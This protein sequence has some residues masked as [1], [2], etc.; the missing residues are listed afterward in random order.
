M[1]SLFFYFSPGRESIELKKP[2][3]IADEIPTEAELTPPINAPRKPSS[4]TD[5]FT[6]LARTFPKPE[7]GTV[8]PQPAKFTRGV[9]KSKA[10]K[11]TPDVTKITIILAG[12]NFVKSIKTCPITQIR[13][14][15]QKALKYSKKSLPNNIL[16]TVI[17]VTAIFW[18]INFYYL[19]IK[20]VITSP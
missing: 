12:V 6:P 7:S 4:K 19:L 17:I 14:P 18:N 8:A 20:T 16:L 5:S 15:T 2:K 13:P 1:S 3:N 9:Y 10:P 11:I